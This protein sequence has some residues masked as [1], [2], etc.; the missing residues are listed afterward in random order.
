M[1]LNAETLGILRERR[2][3]QQGVARIDRQHF[4]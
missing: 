1:P 3:R 4:N 2:L